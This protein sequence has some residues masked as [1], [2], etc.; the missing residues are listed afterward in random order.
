MNSNQPISAIEDESARA[1]KC[2]DLP[3]EAHDWNSN[4]SP[5][6]CRDCQIIFPRFA[7]LDKPVSPDH[8]EV[9][10]TLSRPGN[11][12]DGVRLREAAFILGFHNKTPSG[13]TRRCLPGCIAC[14]WLNA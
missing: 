9:V 12:A 3:Y 8:D 4:G 10:E 11:R 14:E 7:A 13:R 1:V 5:S 2:R 6:F